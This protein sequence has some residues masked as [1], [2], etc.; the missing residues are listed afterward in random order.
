MELILEEEATSF[1][2]TPVRGVLYYPDYWKR[3]KHE[4]DLQEGDVLLGV[5]GPASR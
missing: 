2:A 5:I 3:R 1:Q 4:K